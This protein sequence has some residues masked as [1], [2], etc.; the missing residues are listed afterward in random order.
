MPI[1]SPL[2]SPPK[3]E[4]IPDAILSQH[5]YLPFQVNQ[6]RLQKMSQTQGKREFASKELL[7]Y[8]ML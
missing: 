7:K 8:F 4:K 5:D 2:A 6:N 3:S 1:V